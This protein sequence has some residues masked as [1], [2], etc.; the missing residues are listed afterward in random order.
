VY[1]CRFGSSVQ[2]ATANGNPV[3]VFGREV[4]LQQGTNTAVIN[5]EV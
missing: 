1:P 3:P 5:Y 2:S 4:M